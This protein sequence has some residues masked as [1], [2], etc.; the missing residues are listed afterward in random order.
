MAAGVGQA[1]DL[2]AD[3]RT[4][5]L[6]WGVPQVVFVA[7]FFLGTYRVVLWPV[8]LSA[9]GIAC[10]ANARRCGRLHCYLT[11]PF[12]LLMAGVTG[13]HEM[14]LVSLGPYGW[15]WLGLFVVIGGNLLTYLPERAW[16]TYLRA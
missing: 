3:R 9:M 8:A 14:G 2:V 11:G 7:G 13:V 15:L 16:G 5:L 1:R 10:V 6:L 12:Y 4:R